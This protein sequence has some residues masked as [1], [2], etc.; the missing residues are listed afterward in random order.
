M[1]E[2]ALLLS[3]YMTPQQ[4]AERWD[5]SERT[6]QKWITSGLV[7]AVQRGKRI[8]LSREAVLAF[9]AA[10]RIQ[11]QP[12]KTC[13]GVY[14]VKSGAF[15]KIGIAACIKTR[16]KSIQAH[17]P[18]DVEPVGYMPFG[19]YQDAQRHERWLHETFTNQRHR[20]EWFHDC[21]LL[22]DYIAQHAQPWPYSTGH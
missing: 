9:E 13:Q 3:D 17:N 22:R 18:L 12:L 7:R 5:V 20:Y 1:T 6:V 19:D 11:P 15:I 16:L 2:S 10:H 4:M 8:Y 21:E 14:F